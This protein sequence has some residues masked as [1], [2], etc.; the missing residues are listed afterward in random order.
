MRWTAVLMLVTMTIG[1]SGSPDVASP[2]GP[3]PVG[4][5]GPNTTP[6]FPGAPLVQGGGVIR[7]PD[8]YTSIQAAVDAAE[9]GDKIQVASG[10]YCE[11]VV[12]TKSNLQLQSSPGANRA[13]ITGDCAAVNR[14]DAGIHVMNANGVEIM[15]FIVEYFEMGIQLMNTTGS[16]VHL[17]EVRHITTVPRTGVGAGSRGVG[18]QLRASS[19]NTVSQNDLHENGRNGINIWG[20]S[21]GA[22]SNGNVVRTNRLKDNNLEMAAANVACNLMVNGYARDNTIAENEVLGT[23]GVGIMIGP[24]AGGGR[25][26][27]TGNRFAQNRVHGFGGPGIIAQGASSTGNVIEQND[28]RGNGL[29]W[30]SP[31]NV[32]LFDWSNPVGNTWARNLGSCGPGVC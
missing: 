7:V 28:A 22:P 31:R 20:M 16:R 32:D 10:V 23:Y 29:N 13:V 3:S 6:D 19:S 25:V 30:A 9:P 2:T 17:N 27:V 24:G 4:S 8:D 1:C 11:H 15:G 26:T 5:I 18:I 14:L 21:A 12:I